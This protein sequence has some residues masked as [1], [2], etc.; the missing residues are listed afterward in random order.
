MVVVI[1]FIVCNSVGE[2]VSSSLDGEVT[3]SILDRIVIS[4]ACTYKHMHTYNL[5]C[6]QVK[7]NSGILMLC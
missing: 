2:S 4:Q 6:E 3:L 7:E 5:Y 1:T